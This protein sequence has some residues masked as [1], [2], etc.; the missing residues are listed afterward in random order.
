MKRARFKNIDDDELENRKDFVAQTKTI[1]GGYQR[2]ISDPQT[3]AKRDED[4]RKVNELRGDDRNNNFRTMGY[5]DPIGG[6]VAEQEVATFP[7]RAFL[8][9][10]KY[11]LHI[12]DAG[13]E[14]RC[15]SRRYADRLRPTGSCC[16]R[17]RF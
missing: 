15:R 5:H 4:K 13:A 7:Y 3:K 9:V 14:A 10:L 1:V 11:Y 17:Y 8:S 12:S 2:L 6:R 16:E